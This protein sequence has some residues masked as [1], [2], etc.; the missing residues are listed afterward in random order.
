[1]RPC[2]DNYI[3]VA[4]DELIPTEEIDAHRALELEK[5]IKASGRWKTP[6]T[7][8]RHAFFVMDGHHRLSIAK[9]LKLE[10]MP[11]VLLDY[12]EV[13]V[14][15]WRAGEIITPHLIIAM[16]KSGNKFPYKTTRHIFKKPQAA[17]DIPL[18]KLQQ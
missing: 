1:M 13:D 16:A 10:R 18:Y 7:V 12:T 2:I 5:R 4:P 11:V 6:I 8:H 15:A 14:C 3:L 9:K 17:C